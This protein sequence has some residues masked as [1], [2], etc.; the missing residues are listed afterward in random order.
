MCRDSSQYAGQWSVL[1]TLRYARPYTYIACVRISDTHTTVL[2]TR[3][4]SAA[5]PRT[6]TVDFGTD[7]TGSVQQCRYSL[8]RKN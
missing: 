5:R 4:A 8:E 2:Q 6:L 1:S 3:V 7:R